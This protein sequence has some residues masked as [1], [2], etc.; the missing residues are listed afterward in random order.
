MSSAAFGSGLD[1]GSGLNSG[2]GVDS[3]NTSSLTGEVGGNF[4]WVLSTAFELVLCCSS[5]VLLSSELL[6]EL[7]FTLWAKKRLFEGRLTVFRVT[8]TS[9]AEVSLT[10]LGFE[11]VPGLGLC[12]FGEAL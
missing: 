7:M 1:S 10:D 4:A 6:P 8:W 5:V 11:S 12:G 2:S 9:P 3:S